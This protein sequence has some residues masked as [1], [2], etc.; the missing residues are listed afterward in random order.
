MVS[1]S[2]HKYKLNESS[3]SIEHFDVPIIQGR[4]CYKLK[5]G[6]TYHRSVCLVISGR[7]S[8][9]ISFVSISCPFGVLSLKIILTSQLVDI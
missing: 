1:L 4:K 3:K 8:V 2:R 5:E 9:P 7:G 6:R